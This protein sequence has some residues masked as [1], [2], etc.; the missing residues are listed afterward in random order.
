MCG[1]LSYFSIRKRKGLSELP[2][3][4]PSPGVLPIGGL[5][6]CGYHVPW[7]FQVSGLLGQMCQL[8]CEPRADKWTRKVIGFS[9]GLCYGELCASVCVCVCVW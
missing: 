8:G 6:L 4:S 1:I 5:P 3:C 2:Q 7:H 9:P